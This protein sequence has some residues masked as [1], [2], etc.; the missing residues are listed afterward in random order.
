MSC[1]IVDNLAIVAVATLAHVTSLARQHVLFAIA[2]PTKTAPRRKVPVVWHA[3]LT[4]G[5][6]LAAAFATT[7]FQIVRC[8]LTISRCEGSWVSQLLAY[9]A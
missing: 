7:H 9:G 2:L 5:A 3:L 6:F 1:V 8:I 4:P